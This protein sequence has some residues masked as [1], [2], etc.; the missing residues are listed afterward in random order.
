MSSSVEVIENVIAVVE[1]STG[2]IGPQGPAGTVV[3]DGGLPSTDFSAGVNID[4]GG[5]T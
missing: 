1:V 2:S 3:Y 5:V 4:C